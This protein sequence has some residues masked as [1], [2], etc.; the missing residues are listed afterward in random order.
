MEN[1]MRL[2]GENNKEVEARIGRIRLPNDSTKEIS[3]IKNCS[4]IHGILQ[5]PFFVDRDGYI[6]RCCDT[7]ELTFLVPIIELQDSV[8][9]KSY[10]LSGG[11]Y[12]YSVD[13]RTLVC[14]TYI[15]SLHN[16]HLEHQSVLSDF[17]DKK[18]EEFS[19]KCGE[20]CYIS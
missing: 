14:V 11:A 12:F 9:P 8:E 1:D 2:K 4:P 5:D 6:K 17:I 13:E 15:A 7:G 3:Q 16:S 18:F 19:E 10:Y 20:N